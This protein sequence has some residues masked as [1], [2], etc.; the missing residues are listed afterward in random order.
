[1]RFPMFFA[2]F[3][4]FLGWLSVELRK[5]N[6]QNN[7]NSAS[8]W[9]R[10][11]EA[12]NVRKQT[13]DNLDYITIPVDSLPFFYG[14]DEKLDEVQESVKNLASCRIVNLSAFT[15]TDLKLQYGAANLPALTEY[16]QNFTVLVRT[17]YKWGQQLSDLGY[18]RE[19]IQ[20]LE[21]AVSIHSDVTA[22]YVLLGRLYLNQGMSSKLD[23]LIASV[24]EMDFLL[25]D[26]LLRQLQSLRE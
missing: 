23:S 21:F 13:L 16:D 4:T 11:A 12:N 9:K 3:I 7:S 19:A 25:K 2:L 22:G 8:F 18:E 10:E 5:S 15:N 14:I 1:M 6:K 26:S 20:V 17:L 24:N